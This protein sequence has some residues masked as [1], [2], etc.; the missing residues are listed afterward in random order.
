MLSAMHVSNRMLPSS[1]SVW[2]PNSPTPSS[3]T[4][5]GLQVL[6]ARII[7]AGPPRLT[8]ITCIPNHA[9][10][11]YRPSATYFGSRKTLSCDT[12]PPWTHRC[13]ERFI[14]RVASS[15]ISPRP[16]HLVGTACG[17]VARFRAFKLAQPCPRALTKTGRRHMLA[18]QNGRELDCRQ[19]T[20]RPSTALSMHLQR[21][22]VDVSG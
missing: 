16:M 4:R 2:P 18:I 9:T 3:L 8:I 21:S 7:Y 20:V 6:C 22:I 11:Q 15:R 10:Q 17:H 12:G 5:G 1:A 19:G 14:A 13:E